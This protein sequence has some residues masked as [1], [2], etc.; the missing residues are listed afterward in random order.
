M[1]DKANAA[2]SL[3]LV[4]LAPREWER[5]GSFGNIGNEHGELLLSRP[6]TLNPTRSSVG[7]GYGGH[8]PATSRAR[9]EFLR[10]VL[11]ARSVFGKRF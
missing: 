1:A 2:H 3:S 10:M 9:L 7:A 11:V 5:V 6:K 4:V 8:G